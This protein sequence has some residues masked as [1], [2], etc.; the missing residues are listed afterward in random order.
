M[1]EIINLSVALWSK[2]K[3]KSKDFLVNDFICHIQQSCDCFEFLRFFCG[4]S[5]CSGSSRAVDPCGLQLFLVF[6]IML[7]A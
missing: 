7:L 1:I 4:V 6:L 5:L 2:S 3:A